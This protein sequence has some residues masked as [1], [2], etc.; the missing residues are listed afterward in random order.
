LVGGAADLVR[1][2]LGR[3]IPGFGLSEAPSDGGRRTGTGVES[4]LAPPTDLVS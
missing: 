1:A 4:W 2:S 3:L